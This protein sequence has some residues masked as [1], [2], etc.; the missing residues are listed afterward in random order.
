LPA[1]PPPTLIA[2]DHDDYHAEHVGHTADGRQFFLTTPF[3]PFYEGDGG[4][5][6]VALFLFDADGNFLDAQIDA[7][8]TRAE[9]DDAR[10]EEIYQARLRELGTV[11]FGRIEVRPFAVNRFGTT[12]GLLVSDREDDDEPWW[13]ELHPGNYMAFHEP[14]DSGE[15]DT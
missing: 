11:R 5:E 3:L 2:I 14:W 13:V 15:Y 12:F 6:F 10:G 8:G 1:G 7:L 4:Q 9:V